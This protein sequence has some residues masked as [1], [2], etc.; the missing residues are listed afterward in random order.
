MAVAPTTYE[1]ANWTHSKVAL[2]PSFNRWTNGSYVQYED[3]VRKYCTFFC[4]MGYNELFNQTA[5][6]YRTLNKTGRCVD[7]LYYLWENLEFQK[8]L[9]ESLKK[10][11]TYSEER[12]GCLHVGLFGRRLKDSLGRYAKI[13]RDSTYSTQFNEMYKFKDYIDF[14]HIRVTS[15]A[16][17]AGVARD[18]Q[19]W[20]RSRALSLVDE[21]WRGNTGPMGGGFWS[22]EQIRDAVV[23]ATSFYRFYVVRSSNTALE[24][25]VPI[26]VDPENITY[27]AAVVASPPTEFEEFEAALATIEL[28]GDNNNHHRLT[29]SAPAS[30]PSVVVAESAPVQPLETGQPLDEFDSWFDAAEQQPW[31]HQ[32]EADLSSIEGFGY[33]ELQDSWK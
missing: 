12:D 11:T 23:A 27:G 9:R 21:Y 32:P 2:H 20:F 13:I 29:E 25:L 19:R 14:V 30:L 10:P 28:P 24:E 16:L 15:H 5:P 4:F 26:Y 17:F 33:M 3:A 8:L 22:A 31:L 1:T 7:V 18:L 6:L